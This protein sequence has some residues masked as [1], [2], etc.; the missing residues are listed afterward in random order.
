MSVRDRWPEG[1]SEQLYEALY[2][3]GNKLINQNQDEFGNPFPGEY[4]ILQTPTPSYH[5]AYRW[6]QDDGSVT[7][8]AVLYH[9]HAP[10][11]PADKMPDGFSDFK[12]GFAED[13][14][15]AMDASGFYTVEEDDIPGLGMYRYLKEGDRIAASRWDDIR[16]ETMIHTLR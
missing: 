15:N 5:M 4:L 12:P 7:S 11:L 16:S 14:Y 3:K 1:M 8:Y 6:R 2:D 10:E 13:V 9:R